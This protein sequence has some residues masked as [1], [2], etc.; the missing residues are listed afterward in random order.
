MRIHNIEM[1]GPH[2]EKWPPEQ[3]QSIFQSQTNPKEVD[4][5]ATFEKFMTR[6]FRRPVKEVEL[7]QVLNYVNLIFINMASE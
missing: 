3:H 6:A 5:K 2:Y 1:D 4:I 7:S